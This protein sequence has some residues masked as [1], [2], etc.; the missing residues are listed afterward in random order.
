MTDTTDT[1]AAATTRCIPRFSLRP[2]AGGGWRAHFLFALLAASA[3]LLLSLAVVT[4]AQAAEAVKIGAIFDLTGGLNIYGIQ[5]SHA[6]HL[7]V[8]EINAKGGVVGRPIEIVEADAQSELSKYTQYAN[9]MVMRDRIAALFAGLTSSAREAVRPIARRSDTPYFYSSLY[10]GGACDAQTFVTGPSAS[11]QLSV[12]VRWAVAKYGKRIYVMAADYN[13]GTISA[14]W[15]RTYAKELGAEVVGTEFLPLTVTDFSATIQKIEAARPD[16]VF[17]LPVGTNQTG[18]IEQFSAAGLKQ[19]MGIV[20]TNYGSGNQQIV[21]SPSAGEGVVA[22][23]PYFD[24]IDTPEN[25]LFRGKWQK[26]YGTKEPIVEAAVDT[27]NAVHLWAAAASK[28]GST[29]S[30]KVRQ[31]LESGMV[32]EAPNGTVTLEAASHHLRQSMYI[33]QGNRNRGFDVIATY[34]NV[35][36]SFENERCDL[37]RKPR[38]ATQYMPAGS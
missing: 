1:T 33:A 29:E 14:A 8:D 21:L 31:A 35:A 5:Q 12:L 24:W 22:S 15:V 18:F 3:I 30:V 11:Q 4:R 6:L 28:A 9:T 34:P 36:P 16:F 27:W 7:A 37:L 26:A 17:A 38:T 32:M 2:W 23:L 13:F 10:E 19:K 20:S 25:R